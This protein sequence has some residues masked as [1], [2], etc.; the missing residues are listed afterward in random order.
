M[1]AFTPSTFELEQ[2]QVQAASNGRGL[3]FGRFYRQDGTL[4]AVLVSAGEAE[5]FRKGSTTAAYLTVLPFFQIHHSH[6]KA[7]FVARTRASQ[8]G[9]AVAAAK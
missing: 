8:Q 3:V 7:L 4:V 6:K 1:H 9:S 2:M 5:G